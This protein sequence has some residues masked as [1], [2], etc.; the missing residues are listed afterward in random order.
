VSDL[1]FFLNTH[2]INVIHLTGGPDVIDINVR[3]N[4]NI[5]SVHIKEIW[6]PSPMSEKNYQS[7]MLLHFLSDIG[8][9]CRLEEIKLD[10]DIPKREGIDQSLWEGVDQ[11]LTGANFKFLRKV[12]IEFVPDG[13][14][15]KKWVCADCEDVVRRLPLLRAGGISVDV[16]SLPALT[17]GK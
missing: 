4:P 13:W 14:L 11:I 17:D 2:L 12:D 3:R 8:D 10:V 5:K 6:L 7:R 15:S 9:S 1:N 16:H